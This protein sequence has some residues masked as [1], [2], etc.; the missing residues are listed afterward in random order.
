MPPRLS[1]ETP[2][3]PASSASAKPEPAHNIATVS[4]TSVP[5]PANAPKL[6]SELPASP[7][8]AAQ[9]LQAPEAR[10]KRIV[11]P[12]YPSAARPRRTRGTV[13]LNLLVGA[14]GAVQK[15]N[16]VSGEPVLAKAATQA[17]K[18]W[19]Y[20]PRRVDGTAVEFQTTVRLN[21]FDTEVVSVDYRR[22][23]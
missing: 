17:V 15:V 3:K 6:A 1:P 13:A 4:P 7:P 16:V 8:P 10:P 5:R 20:E 19:R 9:Y 22:S 12:D 14:D 11:Y 2:A 21:F 18:Q 23:E